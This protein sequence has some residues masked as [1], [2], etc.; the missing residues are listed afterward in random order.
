MKTKIN[1]FKKNEIV[2]CTYRDII[3]LDPTTEDKFIK[4]ELPICIIWGRIARID[5]DNVFIIT[6]DSSNCPDLSGYIIPLSL[7]DDMKKI[8][9]KV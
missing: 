7:V 6:E 1:D 8:K 4:E 5:S 2:R 3:F 9:W